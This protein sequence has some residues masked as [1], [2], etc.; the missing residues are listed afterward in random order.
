MPE[1]AAQPRRSASVYSPQATKFSPTN[2]RLI[3]DACD[4]M[5]A[6]RNQSYWKLPDELPLMTPND[7]PLGALVWEPNQSTYRFYG[8]ADDA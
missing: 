2:L 7:E 1:S 8:L 6:G 3:A 4:A 5:S